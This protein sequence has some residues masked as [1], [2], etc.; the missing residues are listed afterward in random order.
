M[1]CGLNKYHIPH[2]SKAMLEQKGILPNTI[3]VWRVPEEVFDY[4]LDITGKLDI[5]NSFATSS[6]QC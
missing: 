4:T 1:K 2:M 5:G 3:E 6:I